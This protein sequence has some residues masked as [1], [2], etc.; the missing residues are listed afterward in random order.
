MEDTDGVVVVGGNTGMVLY[1]TGLDR[2]TGAELEV[3]LLAAMEV[4]KSDGMSWRQYSVKHRAIH[5]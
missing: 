2:G 3:P 4:C 5:M 1:G